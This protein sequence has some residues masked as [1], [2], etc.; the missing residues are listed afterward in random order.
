MGSIDYIIPEI[1]KKHCFEYWYMDD[2][3]YQRFK[4][5]LRTIDNDIFNCNYF[6]VNRYLDKNNYNKLYDD[7][8]NYRDGAKMINS[9]LLTVGIYSGINPQKYGSL[10][11][12]LDEQYHGLQ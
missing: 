4:N 12:L 9:L 1:V 2:V 8:E 6:N 3:E 11:C 7:I 5:N 10:Y